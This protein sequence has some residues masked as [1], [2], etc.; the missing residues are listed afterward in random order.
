[1]RGETRSSRGFGR[2]G[3]KEEARDKCPRSKNA[4]EGEREEIK[5]T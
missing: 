4:N 5:R 2:M 1:L 3:S